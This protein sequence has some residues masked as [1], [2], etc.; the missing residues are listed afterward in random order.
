MD[1]LRR[2]LKWLMGIRVLIVTL[3]LG[4]SIYFQIGKNPHAIPVYYGLISATAL[5]TA[6]YGLIITRT[7]ALVPFAYIQLAGDL[8]IETALVA[9]TGGVESPFSLLYILSIIA[10]SV[11]LSNNGTLVVASSAGILYGVIVDLQYYRVTYHLFPS[12]SWLPTTSL[13]VPEI[14]YNLSINLLGF[15]MVGYLSG[16]L[17]RKLQSAGERLEEKDRD[18]L[19]LQEFHRCILESIESGVFTTSS[20]GLVTSFNRRA[21]EIMGCTESEVRDCLWWEVFGWPASISE[22]ALQPSNL[23]GRIEEMGRRKDGSRLILG[24]S[25]SPLHQRGVRTGLVGVFQDLTPLKKMEEEVRRKQWLA[26][27]G[28]MSAGMAH[29]V[30]NPLAALSGA[31][32]VLRKDLR[33]ADANRSLLDLVLRET[34]RLNGIVNGFLQYARPRP[35]NLKPCHVSE[36]VGETIRMLEQTPPYDTTIRFVRR[37][38]AQSVTTMLDPDQMRQ[39]CW[40]L[41]LNACQAMPQGGTLTVTT[42]PAGTSVGERGGQGVEIVFE[43]TGCGIPED[44]IRKIF[45]PFFTTKEG[46][47][48]LGLSVVHRIMDAH[49]GEVHVDSAPGQGTRVR[50]LLPIRD[51]AEVKTP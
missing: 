27:I 38:A 13:A 3:T 50:L 1:L 12:L 15:V 20:G 44:H 39:V 11:L 32:Q 14:F 16:T 47:T 8:L 10:A 18:L 28:E 21:E 43:D 48:G 9:V 24:M 33:P 37:L 29:E 5:L 26:T 7:R 34:E 4:V 22:K 40:N 51:H 31:I 41:G 30:R 46:G 45:Y 25:L 23:P 17:A 2:K 19:G 36:F 42:R 6:I 35:L 49:E